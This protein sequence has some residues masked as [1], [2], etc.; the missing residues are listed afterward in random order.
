MN[1][2]EILLVL[3]FFMLIFI[4]FELNYRNQLKRYQNKQNGRLNL[5]E[6]KQVDEQAIKYT[7]DDVEH[8]ITSVKRRNAFRAGCTWILTYLNENN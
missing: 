8:I 4:G 6:W 1:T 2:I 3:N 7:S 5:P